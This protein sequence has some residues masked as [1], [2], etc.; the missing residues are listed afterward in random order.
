MKILAKL[1]GTLP[2]AG[3]M[4]IRPLVFHLYQSPSTEQ[5][6]QNYARLILLLVLLAILHLVQMSLG[7]EAVLCTSPMWAKVVSVLYAIANFCVALTQVQ[8][9]F[10]ATGFYRKGSY[11]QKKRG[12]KKY[13]TQQEL[14][15]IIVTIGGQI[16]FFTQYTLFN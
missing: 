15:M 7:I 14:H 4:V 3:K 9:S 12:Y 10:R 16:V 1:I 2:L 13:S 11:P 5:R 8:L 6:S